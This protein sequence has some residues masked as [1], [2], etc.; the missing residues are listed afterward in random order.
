MPHAIISHE[1][2][3][4]WDDNSRALVGSGNSLTSANHSYTL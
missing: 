1:L 4:R 2:G 3:Y